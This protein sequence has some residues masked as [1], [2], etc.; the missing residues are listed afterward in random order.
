MKRVVQ[1]ILAFAFLLVASSS[2]AATH[3]VQ[4]LNGPPRFSPKTL[5]V[6][7]GDTVTWVNDFTVAHDTVCEGVWASPLFTQSSYSF[8]F[9]IAPGNY[10]YVCT[11]HVPQGMVGTITVVAAP[12][13]APTARIVSPANGATFLTTETIKVTVEAS[14]DKAV[15]R[16]DLFVDSGEPINKS[17]PPYEFFL[18]LPAGSH[19][20]RADAWDEA[21]LIGL[22]STVV[23][24][25]RAPNQG[26]SVEITTPSNGAVFTAPANLTIEASATDDAGVTSVQ[27]FVNGSLAGTDT[28]APYTLDR[29][30]SAGAYQVTAVATD[31]EGSSTT[32]AVV[33]IQVNDPLPSAPEVE[34]T[35]PTRNLHLDYT[36]NMVLRLRALA[37]DADGSIAKV[38][39]LEGTNS[40]AVVTAASA[41]PLGVAMQSSK[42]KAS[43]PANTREY[44][45]GWIVR[46]GRHT[47]SAKAT[48]NNGVSA[49]SDPISFTVALKPRLTSSVALTNGVVR[50]SVYGTSGIPFVFEHSDDGGATWMPFLTNELYRRIL[51]FDDASANFNTNRMYKAHSL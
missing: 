28:T 46:E 10:N 21:G 19:S 25:V 13:N 23:V 39:F 24:Q 11:P 9:N 44:T 47:I 51:F 34:I 16:V 5:T 35:Y 41:A 32:S 45:F 49:V 6:Q 36:T 26:P 38:E 8:T 50:L 1:S 15:S 22:S 31:T 12:N 27:F 43:L 40:I 14:D 42:T 20:L 4:M 17:T 30:F 2:E 18:T 29:V 37:G 33:N 3:I 7:A 48:D